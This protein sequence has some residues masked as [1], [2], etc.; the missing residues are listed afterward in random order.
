[1]GVAAEEHP[2][3]IPVGADEGDF[4]DLPGSKRQYTVVFQQHQGLPR[5][6]PGDLHTPAATEHLP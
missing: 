2:G 4:P 5:R 6:L 3:V 1:M